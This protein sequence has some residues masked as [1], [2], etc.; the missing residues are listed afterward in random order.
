MHG[1]CAKRY[2]KIQPENR[3][4]RLWEGLSHA[5]RARPEGRSCAVGTG[6]ISIDRDGNQKPGQAQIASFNFPNSLICPNRSSTRGR[7][8][9]GL[10]T[11]M[12][13]A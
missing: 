1:S 9:A 12:Y 10:A 3:E 7:T 11:A 13:A 4:P 5:A 8:K 6:W 2:L